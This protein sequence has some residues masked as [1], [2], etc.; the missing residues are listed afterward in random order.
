MSSTN[1][2]K[3]ILVICPHPVGFV[4][5]QRLKYEQYFSDWKKNGYQVDVRPFMSV[6]FQKIV[7]KKGFFLNKVWGTVL[8]YLGRVGDLFIIPRYDLVY[9]FLWVTPFG[10]PFFELL[11]SKLAKKMVYDIDDLVF[12]KNERAEPWYALLLKGRQKP[13]FLM[14]RA[15][16]VITCTPFLDSYARQYNNNTTDISSTIN[17]DTYQPV[18]KYNNTSTIT[19]GWSGSHSTIRMLKTIL[20]VFTELKKSVN[21]KLLVMGSTNFELE[22][23]DIETIEWSEEKEIVTLQRIDIGLYPLPLDEEWVKGKSGLKALQYMALGIPTIASNVGC[24]DRVIETGVSGFLV[25]THQE[26]IEKILLLINN[27]ELRKQ[28]GTA[29]RERVEKMYSINA[30]APVYLSILN[31]VIE[32]N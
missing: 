27:P 12:L 7:Y 8:G 30:K 19:L 4:P 10:L 14:K 31:N 20:P 23:I 2:A 18:N 3:R 28:I 6:P 16:H 15:N 13:A 5:G 1:K 25:T 11:M 26:W 9:V 22:G 24:N 29:A 17:T 21:F 32:S